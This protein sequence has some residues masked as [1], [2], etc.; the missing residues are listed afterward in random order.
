MALTAQEIQNMHQQLYPLD[1]SKPD[2]LD[3]FKQARTRFTIA[4]EG[5]RL[6]AYDDATGRPFT[7]PST[8]KGDITVGV[9][10][11]MTRSR[12]NGGTEAQKEWHEVLGDRVSFQDVLEGRVELTEEQMQDLLTFSLNIREKEIEDMYGT[13]LWAVSRA[14]ERVAIESAY[15]NGP[16]LVR[17]GTRFFAAFSSYLKT[18]DLDALKR[19]C[20]E[21]AY[22]SNPRG[23]LGLKRRRE[24]EASLLASPGL[25]F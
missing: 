19:A 2:A 18:G 20:E 23:L 17:S 8:V 16:S 11:N 21:L 15:Y 13:A 22:K 7:D 3:V 12:S 14:N 25:A 5:V 6:R 24:D 10:F 4:Y 1:L 9:G